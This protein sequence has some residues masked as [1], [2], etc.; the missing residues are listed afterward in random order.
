[1]IDTP[2]TPGGE[3]LRTLC[4]A[5]FSKLLLKLCP[6]LVVELVDAF[7]RTPVNND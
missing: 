2:V 6:T 1:V 5:R 7:E 4:C 3:T